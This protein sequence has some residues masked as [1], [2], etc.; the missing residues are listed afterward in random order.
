MKHILPKNI[1]EQVA[2]KRIAVLGDLM[3]DKYTWGQVDRISPEAPVPVFFVTDEE[4][5]LGGA[6]CC[7]SCINTLNAQVFPIGVIGNDSEGE[8]LIDIIQQRNIPITGIIKMK[9]KKTTVKNRCITKQQH[10]MRIDYENLEPLEE[11]IENLLLEK[12]YNESD[13]LDA[14][15]I[16]DYRKTVCSK[17]ILKEVIKISKQKNIFIMVDPSLGTPLDYYKEIDCIKPNRKEAEFFT[18]QKLSDLESI[19]NT[20]AFIKKST[21][22][23]WVTIS[24]DKDGIFFYASTHEWELFPTQIKEVYDVTGAG[25]VVT[26]TLTTCIAAGIDIKSSIFAANVAASLSVSYLGAYYPSWDTIL[27]NSNEQKN[28]GVNIN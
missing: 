13:N 12:L 23:K 8:K 22:A 11:N 18:N 5:R 14:L 19:K 20:A 3:L 26:S 17:R 10:L 21:Q 16:S 2:N 6:A 27:N 24:L 15:I 1:Q 9:N 4:Y 28:Y 7:V 25:D